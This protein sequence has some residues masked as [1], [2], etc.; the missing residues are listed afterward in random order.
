VVLTTSNYIAAIGVNQDGSVYAWAEGNDE[1]Y[2][3]YIYANG[4]KQKVL[5]GE[6]PFEGYYDIKMENGDYFRKYVD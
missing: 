1:E 3:V 2:S 6:D 5:S 4:E